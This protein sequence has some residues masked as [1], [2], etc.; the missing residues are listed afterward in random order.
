MTPGWSSRA[1]T[2]R[3][4]EQVAHLWVRSHGTGARAR[5]VRGKVDGAQD[6]RIHIEAVLVVLARPEATTTVLVDHER[7]EIVYAMAC[8]E[9]AEPAVL[10]FVAVRPSVLEGGR[11]LAA[12][13][14]REL[15][16]PL[17]RVVGVTMEVPI[18]NDQAMKNLGA[19]R[20]SAWY[21]DDSW[22]LRRFRGD[23]D[24]QA[25]GE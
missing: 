10:H 20:Q 3:D 22:F 16:A 11:D 17:P 24:R 9:L 12:E 14:L 23:G 15:L 21:N 19:G 2:P 7:P 6:F 25:N 18:L 5:R 1:A 8:Y 13:M 4:H